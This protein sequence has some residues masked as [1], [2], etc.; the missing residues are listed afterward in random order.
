MSSADIIIP[1]NWKIHTTATVSQ[2]KKIQLRN[3]QR[4]KW[5]RPAEV[6]ASNLERSLS[7]EPDD[8]SW[9]VEAERLTNK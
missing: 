7:A 5:A 8:P 6:R 1:I 2:K 9:R 3:I 4:Q